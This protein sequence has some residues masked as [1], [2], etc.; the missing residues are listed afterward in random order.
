MRYRSG[1]LALALLIALAACVV[2]AGSAM[3]AKKSPNAVRDVVIS[4]KA[5]KANQS[6]SV[7]FKAPALPRDRRLDVSLAAPGGGACSDGY[8]VRIA[9]V[10][11]QGRRVSVRFNPVDGESTVF[12]AGTAS[13]AIGHAGADGKVVVLTRKRLGITPVGG[14][15][16]FGV[17][18]KI[19]LLDGSAITV[20][21]P[22]RPDRTIALTGI[23]RGFVPGRFA[24]NQDI[25]VGTLTGGFWTRSLQVDALCAAA[26]IVTDFPVVPTAAS[27]LLLKASGDATLTLALK[28]DAASLAG[29]ASGGAGPTALTLTGKTTPD[30]LLKL[31]L[32]GSIGGVTIAPGVVATVTF[33]L[34]VNIDLSGKD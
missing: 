25:G 8:A 23:V 28:A 3:A 2:P 17:P 6:V 1:I 19:T 26:P 7:S 34:L 30:G 5:P 22:D 33:N 32:A 10:K 12:C 16:T 18:G 24:P 21:A 15:E 14:P 9:S 4:P 20:R 31:P 13:I 29:C 27:Q 11:P